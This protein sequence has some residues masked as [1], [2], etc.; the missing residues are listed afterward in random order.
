MTGSI[1]GGTAMLAAAL[2]TWVI[3]A[4]GGPYLLAVWLIEY[5][6]DF[7]HA[8]A[9]R[10]PVSVVSGHVL[11]AV[12]G[13]VLRALNL[14]TG[15]EGLHLGHDRRSGPGRHARAYDGGALDRGLPDPDAAGFRRGDPGSIRSPSLLAGCQAPPA[16]SG[17]QAPLARAPARPGPVS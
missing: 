13:L 16:G 6:P 1:R 12:G 7:Q 11:F 14:I 8:A 2:I 17:R 4:L 3:T 15:Q 9:T 5:D 10:L